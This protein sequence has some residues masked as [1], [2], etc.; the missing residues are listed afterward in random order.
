MLKEYEYSTYEEEEE[1]YQRWKEIQQEP[2]QEQEEI[3][4]EEIINKK[5]K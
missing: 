2:E 3:P 5:I 1:G 4:Q